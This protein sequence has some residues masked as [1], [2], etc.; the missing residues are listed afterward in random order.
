MR[1]FEDILN[2]IAKK[3]GVT[4]EKVLQEMQLAIDEA[5]NHHDTSAEP[6]WNMMKCKGKRPTPEEFVMQIATMLEAENGK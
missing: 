5:Y 6:L 2:E 4:V 3:D 1:T